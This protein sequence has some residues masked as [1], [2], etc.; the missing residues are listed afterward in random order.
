MKQLITI[1]KNL[2]TIIILS[3][4]IAYVATI[5]YIRP[6]DK[7]KPKHLDTKNKTATSNN[8]SSNNEP[9]KDVC[10]DSSELRRHKPL[11]KRTRRLDVSSNKEHEV[12]HE[13]PHYKW[14]SVYSIL[15]SVYYVI[16]ISVYYVGEGGLTAILLW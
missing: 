15:C 9:L 16:W 14:N 4:Q 6:H 12:V 5:D 10:W 7:P 13:R 8:V 2:G 3:F 1:F 11:Y